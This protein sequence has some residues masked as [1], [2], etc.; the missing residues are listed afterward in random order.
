MVIQR[1]KGKKNLAEGNIRENTQLNIN[2]I[3]KHT[4]WN[5]REKRREP[6]GDKQMIRRETIRKLK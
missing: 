3:R 5:I 6:K 1:N 2:D 4:G